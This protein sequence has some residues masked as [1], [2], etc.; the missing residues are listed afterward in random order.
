L[1]SST[2]QTKAAVRVGISWLESKGYVTVL[3]EENNVIL[4][5]E[6]DE[7]Y[8]PLFSPEGMQADL[9]LLL[10]ESSLFRKHL[11]SCDLDSLVNL[12]SYT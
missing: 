10:K 2:S 3:Q 4:I 6:P 1:A 11:S 9:K 5:S 12:F 7:A 8:N